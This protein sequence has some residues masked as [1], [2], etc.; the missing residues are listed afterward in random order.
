MGTAAVIAGGVL[1]YA[2]NVFVTTA[3]L[4]TAIGDIGGES[5]YAWTS[6]VFLVASVVSSMLVA[7]VF[8]AFGARGAYL[9]AF[10]V[11]GAGSV[12]CAFAPTM[13]VLLAGRLLQGAGGGV[14][15][16]LAYTVINAVLP[17]QLWT[18]GTSLVS[19]M[20][21]V[22]TF[23]GPTIGGLFAQ[24]GQW[25]WAFGA[26]AIMAAAESVLVV[27]VLPNARARAAT[28]RD[29]FPLWPLVMMTAAALLVSVASVVDQ[30]TLTIGLMVIAVLAMVGFVLVDRRG[31][32][33]VLPSSTYSDSRLKWIYLLIGFVAVAAATE[34]FAPFFGQELG[35]LS[36]LA[37]GFLGA[38]L[39]VGWTVAQIASAEADSTRSMVPIVRVGT[40]LIV[41]GALVVGCSVAAQAGMGRVVIWGIGLAIIGMGIGSTWPHLAVATMR[42]AADSGEGAQASAAINTVQ[43]IAEAVGAAIAGVLVNAGLPDEV[44]AA[45]WLFFGFAILGVVAVGI[46]WSSAVTV[47]PGREDAR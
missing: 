29:R 18:R 13:G 2:T 26:L 36:D 35:G 16:G 32:A 14:L 4:P 42:S 22:G 9:I 37:A 21:G 20:W 43:L 40:L 17:Q 31:P 15:A 6:T 45:R 23:V 24:I 10:G 25:R 33:R 5:F 28:A 1:L 11:F 7:R 46:A 44:A 34:T 8:A 39:A 12:V 27:L 19:A 47:R 30:L 38:A 41:A 3:L